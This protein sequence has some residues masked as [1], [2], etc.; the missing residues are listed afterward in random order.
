MK[1]TSQISL[2]NEIVSALVP[3]CPQ[4]FYN[5][6]TFTDIRPFK[7]AGYDCNV[8]Y[9][10]VVDE[11]ITKELL[12]KQTRYEIN[13]YE[14]G[15]IEGGIDLFDDFY[16]NTFLRKGIARTASSE[17]IR[18][19]YHVIPNHLYMTEDAGVI[20]IRDS[21]R[22]Y[23]IL[24]ASRDGGSSAFCLWEAIK[25][26]GREVDLVGCN[27]YNI[28]LFKRGFSGKLMAYYGVTNV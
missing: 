17:L 21:K 13:R 27:D 26:E 12:E 15:F 14:S 20:M 10:Y 18:R 2:S 28:H 8:R 5:H 16:G 3:Y 22:S 23:Y 11:N 25:A 9:T 1:Y 4:E 19:L 6:Y 7:W 24:G